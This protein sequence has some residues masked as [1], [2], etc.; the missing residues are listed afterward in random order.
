M[1]N[2]VKWFL[3]ALLFGQNLSCQAQSS[4]SAP[5]SALPVKIS[6]ERYDFGKITY[7]KPVAYVITLTN[8]GK[9]TLALENVRPGCGCTTPNFTPG[10]KFGPGQTVDITIGFNSSVL[11]KFTRFTDIILSGGVVRQTSFTGEGI[12]Q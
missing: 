11:G 6:N 10:Q 9:D 4:G 1:R 8:E 3:L 12:Q 7:G 2:P 5:G